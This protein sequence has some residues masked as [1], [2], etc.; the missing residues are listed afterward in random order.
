M[1][2]TTE[3]WPPGL[4]KNSFSFF[5]LRL[6][7]HRKHRHHIDWRQIACQNM[8]I[9]YLLRLDL[10]LPEESAQDRVL[11][12]HNSFLM[13][14]ITQIQVYMYKIELFLVNPR[15]QLSGFTPTECYIDDYWLI[16]LFFLTGY[17]LSQWSPTL[18]CLA[19]PE[20]GGE[21]IKLE[22]DCHLVVKTLCYVLL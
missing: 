22:Q 10:K 15:I 9:Q 12:V 19:N 5:H 4:T 18:T 8:N 2:M 14:S 6:K 17:V 16:V 11:K 21:H 13:F 3:S 1:E 7:L 20:T